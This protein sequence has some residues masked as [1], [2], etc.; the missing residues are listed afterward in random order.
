MAARGTGTARWFNE[1]RGEDR[2]SRG[3]GN[4]DVS[5]HYSD[6]EGEGPL[7]PTLVLYDKCRAKGIR[8]P[9]IAQGPAG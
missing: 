2:I 5:V 1:I 8:V 3:A 7:G 9:H 4:R 6:I